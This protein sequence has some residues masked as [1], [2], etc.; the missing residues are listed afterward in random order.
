MTIPA[1]TYSQLEKFETC[2]KQFYHVRVSKDVTEP[3][4]D[5][6]KW[7]ER[8]HTAFEHRILNGTALPEGMGQWEGIATKIASMKGDIVC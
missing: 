2:P 1:W 8:V 6:T 4:T 5:A 7:G 3:P